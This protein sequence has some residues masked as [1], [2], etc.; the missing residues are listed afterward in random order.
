SA[1]A[2][3]AGQNGGPG[4]DALSAGRSSDAQAGYG[5]QTSHRDTALGGNSPGWNSPNINEQF[6][7]TIGDA[8]PGVAGAGERVSGDAAPGTSAESQ[9]SAGQTVSATR[10]TSYKVERFVDFFNT[11]PL[12]FKIN[13]AHRLAGDVPEW[14]EKAVEAYLSGAFSGNLPIT[15]PAMSSL[16]TTMHVQQVQH[17]QPAV[18]FVYPTYPTYPAVFPDPRLSPT[19]PRMHQAY[20]SSRDRPSSMMTTTT[21]T[22]HLDV[23]V[24]MKRSKKDLV[25]GLRLPSDAFLVPMHKHRER[26]L[27]VLSRGRPG[28]DSSAS[29][30][31]GHHLVD[32]F[33]LPATSY[34][35]RQ[36]RRG[37]WD[38]RVQQKNQ[39][40][41]EGPHN[42]YPP[43]VQHVR[44]DGRRLGWSHLYDIDTGAGHGRFHARQ[45]RGFFSFGALR[46]TRAP[47][48]PSVAVFC[49]GQ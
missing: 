21:T 16:R 40:L 35:V 15:L 28:V 8:S 23:P 25:S 7:G 11:R 1:E 17:P 32:V 9:T 45:R 31:L 2:T 47:D 5:T 49:A 27:G 6:G 22:R 19:D 36:R 41:E 20:Y 3:S 18:Q 43:R 26:A 24:D 14:S 12:L 10:P 37:P 38:P 42:K 39:G 33:G 4:P 46:V 30:M 13:R 48:V 34:P 44:L 29:A